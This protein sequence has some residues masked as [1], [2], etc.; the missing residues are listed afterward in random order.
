LHA[1]L[2]YITLALFGAEGIRRS[3]LAS[4]ANLVPGFIF[5]D[6]IVNDISSGAI[7]VPDITPIQRRRDGVEASFSGSA[8]HLLTRATCAAAI[9]APA[10]V[11]GCV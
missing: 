10:S 9:A 6:V 7:G 11:G 4:T 5:V 3:V 1:N 2:P 8:E